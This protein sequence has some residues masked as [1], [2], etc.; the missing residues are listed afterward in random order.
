[1]HLE[2]SDI[3]PDVAPEAYGSK[4]NHHGLVCEKQS[5]PLERAE[6]TGL[7]RI[8]AVWRFCSMDACSFLAA[9]LPWPQLS[10]KLFSS[11]LKAAGHLAVKDLSKLQG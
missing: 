5:T 11:F 2:L 9:A 10:G 7:P 3:F 8:S 1:M 6:T 4:P